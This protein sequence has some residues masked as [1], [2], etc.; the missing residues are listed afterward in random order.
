[1]S[2]WRSGSL[3]TFNASSTLCWSTGIRQE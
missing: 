1:M 2:R 3:T